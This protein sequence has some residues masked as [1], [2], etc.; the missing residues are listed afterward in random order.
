MKTHNI[1]KDQDTTLKNLKDLITTFR[2]ERGWKK[3]HNPKD[4]AISISIEANE[5]LEIFQWK[6]IEEIE[7]ILNDKNIKEKV[8]DELADIIIYSLSLADILSS[9]VSTIVAR[10]VEKNR[11][12]YPIEKFKGRY[13]KEL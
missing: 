13:C 12:K 1:C 8:E 2:D 10:K 7:N 3:Y 4:L 9:D 11:K 5:L 6:S